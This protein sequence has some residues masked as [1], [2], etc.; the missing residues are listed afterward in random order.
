MSR[1]GKLPVIV[2]KDVSVTLFPGNFVEIKGTKG[3]LSRKFSDEVKISYDEKT[4]IVT[5]INDSI[6]AKAKWG[7]SRKLLSNMMIGVTEGFIKKLEVNGVGYKA[8]VVKGDFLKLYLGYS[9]TIYVAI[10]KG[11]SVVCEKPT[12]ISLSGCNNEEVGQF[13]AEIRKLRKPE[14][15]KGKGIRYENEKVRRKEG[16]KK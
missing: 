4:L 1:I 8:E 16:K 9:H 15:Y 2:S 13:A 11:I 12:L 10:P 3:S 5:P 14:P 7:L 6:S